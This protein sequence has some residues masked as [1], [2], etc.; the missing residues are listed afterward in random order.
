MGFT[1]GES[2]AQRKIGIQ[3]GEDRQAMIAGSGI[4]VRRAREGRRFAGLESKD[5]DALR[6]IFESL[7]CFHD[8]RRRR[9]SLIR[10]LAQH[11]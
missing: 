10:T 2:F 7:E 5:L 9:L 4:V 6:G 1:G 8:E 3:I 11:P